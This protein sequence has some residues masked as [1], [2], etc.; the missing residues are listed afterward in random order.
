MILQKRNAINAYIK[1]KRVINS[2][3]TID[4]LN[5]AENMTEQFYKLFVNST[6]TDVYYRILL[7][8]QLI[9]SKQLM[10]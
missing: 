3:K 7:E 10:I 6:R 4:Q 8:Q 9:I 5:V 2:C 1:T